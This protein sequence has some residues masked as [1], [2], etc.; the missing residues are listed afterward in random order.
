MMPIEKTYILHALNTLESQIKGIRALIIQ[1]TGVN[2]QAMQQPVAPKQQK[3]PDQGL[4][5]LSDDE[6]NEFGQSIATI[7]GKPVADPVVSRKDTE[8]PQ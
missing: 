7:F 8:E 6:E 2:A 1:S 4:E 3:G 5:Y